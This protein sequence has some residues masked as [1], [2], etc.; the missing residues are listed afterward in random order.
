MRATEFRD[1]VIVPACDWLSTE[2]GRDMGT[3]SARVLMLAIAVQESGLIHRRQLGSGGRPLKSLARG[4]W[5]FEKGG[6]V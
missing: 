5:Q 6:G 4:W 3:E 1:A 2:S